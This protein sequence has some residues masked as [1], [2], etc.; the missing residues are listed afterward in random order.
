MARLVRRDPHK[1]V[2]PGSIPGA[3]PILLTKFSWDELNIGNVVVTGSTPVVSSTFGRM[4]ELA[5]MMVL[6]TIALRVRVRLLLRLPFYTLPMG[7][8]RIPHWF[9]GVCLIEVPL[10]WCKVAV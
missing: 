4:M 3:P 5:D 6:E 10:C 9:L 8:G 1:V 7:G 2:Y